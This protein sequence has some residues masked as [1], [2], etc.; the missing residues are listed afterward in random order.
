MRQKERIKPFLRRLDLTLLLTLIKPESIKLCP[1]DF[2]KIVDDVAAAVE[3]NTNYWEENP[4][5]RFAQLMTNLGFTWFDGIYYKEETELLLMLG[6]TAEESYL[7]GSNYDKH[8]NR[9][10]KTVFRFIDELDDTHLKI[11]IDEAEEGK[12][13][14]PAGY[15]HLFQAELSNRGFTNIK[16]SKNG[17]AKQE[18]LQNEADRLQEVK[19]LVN[20]KNILGK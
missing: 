12:R 6:Y 18:E 17:W 19:T 9:L 10:A 16:L 4:D 14:Y 8:G 7:W 20:I 3:N 15:L 5:L 11:M 2:I 13:L 1:E